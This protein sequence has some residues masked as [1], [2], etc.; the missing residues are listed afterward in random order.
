MEWV[1]LARAW[2]LQKW[3]GLEIEVKS[4]WSLFD[5]VAEV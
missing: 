1:F 2:L 3:L 5:F 4:V